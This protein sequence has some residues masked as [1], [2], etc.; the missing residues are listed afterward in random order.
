VLKSLQ[1]FKESKKEIE[2]TKKEINKYL[3]E[4][5]ETELE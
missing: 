4:L 2:E 5:G 1:I 3:K